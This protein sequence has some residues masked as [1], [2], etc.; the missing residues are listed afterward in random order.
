MQPKVHNVELPRRLGVT[1]L[2]M[3]IIAFNAP[4]VAMAGFEQLT[5]GRGNGIGAPVAFLVAGGILLI[6]SVGFVGMSRYIE[7]PGAF[8]RYIVAGLGRPA[9]LAGAFLATTGYLLLCAGSYPYLGLVAISFM[10]GAFGTSLMPWEAWSALFLVL[11][12]GIGLLRIDFSA[13]VFGTLVGVEIALATIWQLAVILKGGPEGYS[14]HSFSL[15][16]FGQGSISLGVLFAMLCMCG[17]EAAAC[18]SGEAIE[19]NRSVGRATYIAI[20]FLA[21][22]YSSSTWLYI[23]AQ[24]ASHAVDAATHDPVESFLKGVHQYLGAFMFKVISLVVVTSQMIAINAAQGS[25]SRYLFA[26]GRDGVLPSALGKVHRRLQSP[27]VAIL[28]VAGICAVV[29]MAIT[30]L[31]VDAVEAYGG[32]TGMG[33]YFLLPLLAMTA[34]AVITFFHA[35]PHFAPGL[36]VRLIAPAV[37]CVVLAALFVVISVNLEILVGTHAMTIA[38]LMTVVIIPVAGWT[39]AVAYRRWRPEVYLTIGT[40]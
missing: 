31:R 20:I 40:Q 4:L 36:W 33:I 6:F 13:K 30:F 15:S 35:N 18:F 9:G 1:S 11:I 24:G 21:I 12:T 14:L 28:C 34:F 3:L 38:S 39:L 22:F 37:S 7:N 23:V 27:Y 16:A 29:L 5:I 17:I 19:P 2:V 32:L 25:A 10:S 8:Y 26:L